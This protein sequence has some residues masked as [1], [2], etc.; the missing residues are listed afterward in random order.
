MCFDVV[1]LLIGLAI[2]LISCELFTNS[3]EWLGRKLKVG[4]GVIGSIFSAVGTCLPETFVPVIAI[5]LSKSTKSSVNIAIGAIVGAPFMLSTLA[6]FMTGISVLIFSRRRMTGFKMKANNNIVCRDLFFFI[7]AYS[8]G[9][10]TSF[11][12]SKQVRMLIVVFLIVY[13]IYYVMITV[14]CDYQTNS[15]LETLHIVRFLN[16]RP[17]MSVILLQIVISLLGIF[18]GAELF[19]KNMEIIS[20]HVGISALVLSMMI[21]PV[22]TELPEKFNSIIWISK[23]KD[24]LALGNIT[25]ALVFQS[26]IPVAIG[27]AATPW[28]LDAKIIMSSVLAIM[29]SLVTLLWIKLKNY[30]NPVPLIMGAFFYLLFVVILL[31]G[32]VRIING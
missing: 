15:R 24:T 32:S 18:V 28:V 12:G 1:I 14:T 4:D 10:L 3:I 9:I 29:S 16:L 17:K 21:T 13:Y 8:V 27:I 5:L 6:F 7:I 20:Q 26:C 30:L 25:G 31:N 23:K 11:S 19:V 2:I 22:A